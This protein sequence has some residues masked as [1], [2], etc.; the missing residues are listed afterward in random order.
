[1]KAIKQESSR[2]IEVT[3]IPDRDGFK[4]D[5]LTITVGYYGQGTALKGIILDGVIMPRIV[6]ALNSPA[7][8][9]EDDAVQFPRLLAEVNAVID[10]DTI[11]IVAEN[12]DLTTDE[13]QTLFDRAEK[14]WEIIKAS[15]KN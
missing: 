6:A 3:D 14:A 11:C 12:M 9:W 8:T 15:R 7:E 4:I 13:V 2:S 10:I 5:N 1:M